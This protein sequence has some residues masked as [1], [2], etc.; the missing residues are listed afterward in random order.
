MDSYTVKYM[1]DDV[2]SYDYQEEL[3]RQAI[4]KIA[5]DTL[6]KAIPDEWYTFRLRR[7]VNREVN[8]Y[9]NTIDKTVSYRADIGSVDN[10][11]VM[12]APLIEPM[13]VAPPV[14]YRT[15]KEVVEV[16]FAKHRY[17]AVMLG[18]V[19]VLVML[20]VEMA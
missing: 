1:V 4:E 20:L 12:I 9:R 8:W 13:L 15:I 14:V 2:W 7:E 10:G 11:C 19:I 17:Q 6:A 16:S 18:L 3:E 5:I